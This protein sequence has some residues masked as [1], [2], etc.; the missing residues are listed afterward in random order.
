[1]SS[2]VSSSAMSAG[3]LEQ[4][5]LA[6][7]PHPPQLPVRTRPR[8]SSSPFR[9]AD[10]YQQQ[11]LTTDDLNPSPYGSPS[12]K[13]VNLTTTVELVRPPTHPDRDRSQRRQPPTLQTSTSSAFDA[14]YGEQSQSARSSPASITGFKTP[15]SEFPPSSSSS[16]RVRAGSSGENSPIHSNSQSTPT[17]ALGGG[18]GSGGRV[19]RSRSLHHHSSSPSPATPNSAVPP[20]PANMNA[21]ILGMGHGGGNGAPEIPPRRGKKRPESMQ[22]LPSSSS[23]SHPFFGSTTQSQNV[24]DEPTV[25]RDSNDDD[26]SHNARGKWQAPPRH[27][28]LSRHS[29]VGSSG[30]VGHRKSSLSV[31]AISGTGGSPFGDDGEGEG[32]WGRD[33]DGAS[34]R[35]SRSPVAIGMTKKSRAN[36]GSAGVPSTTTDS[37]TKVPNPLKTAFAQTKITL[38]DKLT[39]TFEQLQPKLEKARYKAEAGLLP[40]RGFVPPSAMSSSHS[41]SSSNPH[42]PLIHGSNSDGIRKGGGGGIHRRHGEDER[43]LILSRRGDES[44]DD[45]GPGG[46]DSG[47]E[48][49]EYWRTGRTGRE[50]DDLKWP[51]GEGEGWT[52]L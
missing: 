18:S 13:P 51:V 26:S 5:A 37:S 35:E 24:F 52:R 12:R 15:F 36:S 30:K 10:P 3:S 44:S 2:I 48:D 9:G 49:D 7:P 28:S 29:S 6:S 8:Q 40:R 23:S 46:M 32:N 21:K 39:E 34:D 14:V 50:R 19:W 25:D 4:V 17:S 27:G 41:H 22:V 31:S 42:P 1:M 45:G 20:L 16:L 43:G 11:Q 33:R 38:N 47:P